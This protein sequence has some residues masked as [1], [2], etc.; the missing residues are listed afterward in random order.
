[1]K[2]KIKNVNADQHLAEEE[3]SSVLDSRFTKYAFMSLE[4]RA[5]PDARDG[6]KP[7][8][9]RVL[10][11]MSDLNLTS[12][13]GTEKC[14]KICGDT[15]GNYHPHGEAVVYPTLYRLAQDWV[16]RYPL[17][18]G[19][20]NFGNVDGDAPAAMRYCLTGDA[21]INVG[22]LK[23][24]K[25]ISKKEKIDLTV[26][27]IDGLN[28]A[29][30]WFDC[31]QHPVK[32]I[33]T[34][35]K[36][37][38]TGTLNH[39]LFVLSNVNGIP[40]TDWK[41]LEDLNVGDFVVLKR[42]SEHFAKEYV[43]LEK[44]Y[45]N[46]DSFRESVNKFDL[47]NY[48][49]ENLAFVFGCLISEGTLSS[50]DKIS[51]TNK[52]KKYFKKYINCFNSAL[53]NWSCSEYKHGP[54]HSS[55]ACGIFLLDFLN[56]LGLEK[57]IAKN[58]SVPFVILNSPKS[59]ISSFLQALYEGDGGVCIGP[60]NSFEVTYNSQSFDLIKQVQILLLQFGIVAT[61]YFDKSRK[62]Y[63]LIIKGKNNFIKFKSEI[64]FFSNKKKNKLKAAI[65]YTT[66]KALSK[67]DYVPYVSYFVRKNSIKN[68]D[69]LNK[70]NFDRIEN[71]HKHK[72]I[73]KESLTSQ[74]FEIISSL[75]RD[76]FYYDEVV[77]IED[78]GEQNVYSVKVDSK[79]HSFV[80]NGFIN[81][82]T[83][84]KLS[85]FGE[86]LLSD[87][88]QDVVPFVPN[89][90]EKRKEPTILP[91]LL[92]NLLLN[93]CEGIAV[94][95]ATKMLPHNLKEIVSVIKEYIKNPNITYEKIVKLMPGPDFPTGGKLLGQD[96]V[97]DYYKT[98]RGSIKLEGIY[99]VKKDK[100]V[101][102]EL[103]YQTSPDQFC[104]EIKNLV[105]SDKLVGIA[106]LKN[107]SS[108]KTGIN[109]VIDVAKNGNAN[110][111]LNIL[112]KQTCLRKSMSVNSTVL[113]D[114]KVVPEANILQLIKAFVDHR[115]V[116]LTNKF[117]SEL[118]KANARIHILDGLI[119]IL[120]KIE[121]VVRLILDSENAEEAEK[122]LIQKKYVSSI[123]QAKAVLAIT[124]RQITKLEGNNLQK[125]RSNL[126]DRAKWL[127]NILSSKEEMSNFIVEQQEELV[128]KYGDDR[129]TRIEASVVDIEDEDL[130]K[131][132]Q[133]IISLT[134]DGYVRSIPVESYRV[135]NRGGTGSSGISKSDSNPEN[136]FEMFESNSKSLILFFT[137]KGLVYQRKAYQIPIASKTGKGMHVSNL[138]SLDIN[139]FVTNMI[140]IKNLSQKGFLTIVTKNGIIKKTEI[141][142]YDTNRKTGG[143]T[144]LVLSD[145]DEVKFACVT[146]GKRDVFIVTKNGQCVRYAEKIITIQ[147]R[148]TRGSKALK[149]DSSDEVAQVFTLSKEDM[150]DILVV[151]AKGFGKKTKAEEYKS[152]GN[153][154]VKGYSVIKKSAL[155][156]NGSI[157]GACAVEKGDSIL[158]MTS[159]GK[160]IRIDSEDIKETGR[161]TT[162]VKIIKLEDNDNVVKITRVAKQVEV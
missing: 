73:I 34:R 46:K 85:K 154:N 158:T 149:L 51:F 86:C 16:L 150:P 23:Q 36:Y 162:G 64:G 20:G 110:L 44:F 151:T 37:S 14:A 144:A 30:K 104:T 26:E 133:L 29:S 67:K 91:A 88:S 159:S 33:Q 2:T 45:P 161:T 135:Q 63:K 65:L 153:R 136:I 22:G 106:D 28:N 61:S 42:G 90:N 53:P 68:K 52:D 116:V 17:L 21:L 89:Y 58:K 120:D 69:F 40:K 121:K 155:V 79:C 109:I 3:L 113:I 9:R 96:G 59:V 4:D 160:C 62:I 25:S 142:E 143:L 56:N 114:G 41:T 148:S 94:G 60:K 19:Q 80:A 78:A 18:S 92:P 6:L 35:C 100:I 138:L 55:D 57:S 71:W 5:L 125:E 101:I 130:I 31:G 107:L 74:N 43:S 39:P 97:L 49:N 12:T 126:N 108:K 82:N 13:S 131:N 103:P 8:Q 76:D 112:L 84:A 128:K 124:L 54:C 129:R 141:S 123:E 152:L 99:D 77:S 32:K 134:G 111:I 24:I 87:L 38:I 157:I 95:W 70:N 137:N 47:P 81:H 140:T 147:G 10:V 102:S 117:T 11:A 146:D 115:N 93:G 66:G 119:G 156:K 118:A 139:E 83:E 7:S 98:G 50:Y 145:G 15:S 1:M 127:K 72:N 27:S 132:E 75:M 105:E 48:L 122:A